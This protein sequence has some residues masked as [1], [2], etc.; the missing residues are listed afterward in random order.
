MPLLRLNTMTIIGL[1]VVF[2]LMLTPVM[3][4][5]KTAVYR[6]NINDLFTHHD[7]LLTDKSASLICNVDNYEKCE[8]MTFNNER[9]K[10][11][12]K[13]ASANIFFT[14]IWNNSEQ[15]FTARAI[16]FGR[17]Y[18]QSN[19]LEAMIAGTIIISGGLALILFLCCGMSICVNSV[20]RESK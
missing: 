17:L 18:S 7:V 9:Y 11:E 4:L 6:D 14:D 12:Y 19:S 16:D 3:L 13:D 8:Y 2:I 20:R 10:L 5:E 15:R 1:V